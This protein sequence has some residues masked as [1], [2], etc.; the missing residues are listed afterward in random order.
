MLAA[1]PRDRSENHRIGGQGTTRDEKLVRAMAE[2]H[3]VI[4]WTQARE[5]GFTHRMIERRLEAGRLYRQ[6]PEVY[7]L[8]PSLTAAGRMMAAA[9]SC[10][11]A[12]ALSH[13]AGAAV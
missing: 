9:L 5:L 2:Q 3:G 12:A 8:T 13:R 10:A 7:S 4:A 1:M 6:Q 11:P